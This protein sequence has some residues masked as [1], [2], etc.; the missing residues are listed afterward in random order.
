MCKFKEYDGEG[1]IVQT[2]Q[3]GYVGHAQSYRLLKYPWKAI[4]YWDPAVVAKRISPFT[5]DISIYMS[6]HGATEHDNWNIYSVPTYN[7]TIDDATL[8]TNQPRY[9]F[10]T[11]VALLIPEVEYI[12]VEAR[13]GEKVLGTSETAKVHLDFNSDE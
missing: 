1:K 4:P 9:G 3:F 2:G 5:A 12:I 13:Q 7:S 6:W 8:L 10:E 11:H